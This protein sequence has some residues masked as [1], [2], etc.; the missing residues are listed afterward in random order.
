MSRDFGSYNNPLFQVG[1][2]VRVAQILPSDT[3]TTPELIG[4]EGTVEEVEH[5]GGG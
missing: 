1:Q 4:F 5:V 2:R 3:I